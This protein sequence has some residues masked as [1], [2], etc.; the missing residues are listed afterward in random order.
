MEGERP[1]EPLDTLRFPAPLTARRANGA[2][3]LAL[4]ITPIQTG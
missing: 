3:C 2:P 1:R 4:H